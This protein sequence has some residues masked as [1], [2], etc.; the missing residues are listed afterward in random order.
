VRSLAAAK[1]S[2]EK[3]ERA[4]ALSSREKTSMETSSG[5]TVRTGSRALVFLVSSTRALS[6]KAFWASQ[7]AAVAFLPLLHEVGEVGRAILA[8]VA[9]VALEDGR[10][11]H[12]GVAEEGRVLDFAA[13]ADR[14]ATLIERERT[15]VAIG[16]DG[17]LAPR[18]IANVDRTCELRA[19]ACAPFS[20][21]ALAALRFARR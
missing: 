19:H 14:A 12:Q 16:R 6:R 1:R 20:L 11:R 5:W 10:R 21:T 9:E 3:R 8:L 2:F 17:E 7:M 13:D 18:R 15:R 4:Y